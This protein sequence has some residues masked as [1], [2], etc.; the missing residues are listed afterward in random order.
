MAETWARDHPKIP[1]VKDACEYKV[2]VEDVAREQMDQVF[3]QGVKMVAGLDKE[4]GLLVAKSHVAKTA[5]AFGGGLQKSPPL[6]LTMQ[7]EP[8]SAASAVGENTD[9]DNPEPDDEQVE[10]QKRLAQFEESET[11][12]IKTA[13][14][15]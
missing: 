1:H 2:M 4:H 9:D 10:R 5:A 8:A 6:A 15:K 3:K 12:R 14:D 11:K 13:K 7:K